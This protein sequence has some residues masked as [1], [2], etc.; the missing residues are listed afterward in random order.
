ME[1][2]EEI[3]QGQTVPSHNRFP[4]YI[5]PLVDFIPKNFKEVF[6]F[7]PI[8]EPLLNF[9]F[10]NRKHR[11]ELEEFNKK[12]WLPKVELLLATK[13]NALPLRDKEHK[14]TKDICDIFAL[15]WYAGELTSRIPKRLGARIP[16]RIPSK[17]PR[18]LAE[19]VKQ[20]ITFNKIKQAIKGITKEDYQKAGIQLNHSAEEIKRVIELLI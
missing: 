17:L 2:E 1:T 10:T 12:L 11:I 4:M 19:E 20:F 5:D 3:K 18:D 8:D 6:K 15:I 13:L 14:K 16:E 7:D 9:A